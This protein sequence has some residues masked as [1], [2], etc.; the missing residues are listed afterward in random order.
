MSWFHDFDF[1]WVFGYPSPFLLFDS[2]SFSEHTALLF[3][4]N[5]EDAE[6]VV[7][8]MHC[9]CTAPGERGSSD[10]SPVQLGGGRS[11]LEVSAASS[12][13]SKSLQ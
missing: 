6:L 4:I 8:R 10:F 7:T 1:Q 9:H 5:N 12:C 3:D 11:A 2:H 13:L